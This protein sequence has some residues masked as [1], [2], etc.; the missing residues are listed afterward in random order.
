[1][2]AETTITVPRADYVRVYRARQLSCVC[3]CVR[4]CVYVYE[5]VCG[6]FPSGVTQLLRSGLCAAGAE[7]ALDEQ[8][9]DACGQGD[10]SKAQARILKSVL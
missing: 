7:R 1:V 3:V 6:N 2:C 4:V 9:L 5:C 10:L 8:L